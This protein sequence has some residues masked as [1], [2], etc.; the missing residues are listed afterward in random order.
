MKS[1]V[2]KKNI[3]RKYEFL[4]AFVGMLFYSEFLIGVFRSAG[5]NSLE[6]PVRYSILLGSIIG[7]LTNFKDAKKAIARGKWLWPITILTICSF[8]WSRTPP[9]TIENLRAAF[10]PVNIFAVFLATRFNRKQI[11]DLLYLTSTVAS[12]V[13][14]FYAIAIPS[15]G[16]HQ[17]GSAYPGAWKGVFSQK[18]VFGTNLAMTITLTYLKALYTKDPKKRLINI[19]IIA[20]FFIISNF[21]ESTSAVIISLVIMFFVWC[22]KQFRWQ[23]KL[24]V[25]LL[26]ISVMLVGGATV[27]IIG[28]WNP[29][30]AAL[31][32][33]PTMS[34]RTNIWTFVLQYRVFPQSPILGFGRGTFWRNPALFNGIYSIA[35]HVPAHAHNGYVDLMADLGLAGLT[36]FIVSLIALVSRILKLAYKATSVAD[37]W[38]LSFILLLLIGN[39]TESILMRGE[40]FNWLIYVTLL[41]LDLRRTKPA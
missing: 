34:E 8:L 20:I 18:N 32:K 41:C 2:I 3:I 36:F 28:L 23:G 7:I 40:S 6:S 26:D 35:H 10:I 22:Y 30:M 14:V 21:S 29:I 17:A 24:T 11:F 27:A 38:P 4:L 25:F 12:I 16:V 39:V 9:I 15:V 1:I 13:C 37:V 33:D 31:G 19:G 5:A